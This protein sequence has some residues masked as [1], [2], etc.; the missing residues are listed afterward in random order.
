MSTYHLAQLNIAQM[1]APLDDPTMLGFVE[2]IDRINALA[3][4][5]PGFIW[6]LIEEYGN[7][8][9]LRVLKTPNY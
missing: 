5:S 4:Q 8:T 3:E 1:N 6:R 7:A 9:S 2:Q